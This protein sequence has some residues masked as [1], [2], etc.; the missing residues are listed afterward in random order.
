MSINKVIL[1]GR[2]SRMNDLN[3]ISDTASVLNFSVATNERWKDKEGEWVDKPTFHNIVAWNKTAETISKFF[4][5]GNQIAIEGKLQVRSY[6]KDEAETDRRFVTE[7]IVEKFSFVDKKSD[8]GENGTAS[9]SGEKSKERWKN[10]NADFSPDA[11]PDGPSPVPADE[12]L[13]F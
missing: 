11:E 8:S 6:F 3:S 2:I 4:N 10:Q 12:D 13:P 1:L 9:P 7:I 5:V